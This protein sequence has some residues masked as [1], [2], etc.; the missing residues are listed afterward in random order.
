MHGRLLFHFANVVELL[1]DFLHQLESFVDVGILPATKDDGKDDFV[2]LVKEPP[3][4]IDLRFEIMV[5]DL[6]TEADFLIFAVMSVSLVVPLFLLVLEF[7]KVHNTADGWIL[8][9]C[10][11]YQIESC[12]TRLSES[13]VAA[14]NPKLFAFVR[15]H[16]KG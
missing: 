10:D 12:L 13:I 9:W 3:G 1:D 8:G 7:T 15:N 4:A 11:F 16:T 14:D 6:G 2:F 5:A